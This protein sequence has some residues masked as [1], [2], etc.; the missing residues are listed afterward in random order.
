MPVLRKRPDAAV[1][2]G[3][4]VKKLTWP[5]DFIGKVI[6]GDCLDVLPLI[7]DGAVD[8]IITS[9]PYDNL[10]DYQ[11]FNFDYKPIGLEL[12]RVIKNGGVVVWVVGDSVVNGSETGNS[13]RQALYFMEVGFRLHDTMIYGKNGFAFPDSNRYQQINEYMFVLSKGAPKTFNPI[14]RKNRWGGIV[15]REFERQKDG[16][17]SNSDDRYILEEGNYGNIWIYNTGY[18]HSTK[19]KVAYQHPAIFPD[20]LAKDHIRSWTNPTD[21]ILD[22]MMGSGT[23]AVAAKQLGRRYIGIEISP[24]YCKI[25]E[26]RLRQGELFGAVSAPPKKILVD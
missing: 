9:P 16:S 15:K 11:E 1:K 14:K 12:F 21:V 18:M 25:A 4:A 26:D 5:Q 24:K 7:P 20:N 19:D 6:C 22:P 10:R 8:A 17:I 13:F 3:S 2:G 23:V